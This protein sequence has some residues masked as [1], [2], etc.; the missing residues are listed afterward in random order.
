M[1]GMGPSFL[2]IL[3]QKTTL[4]CSLQRGKILEERI[5]VSMPVTVR[6]HFFFFNKLLLFNTF[7]ILMNSFMDRKSFK[8]YIYCLNITNAKILQSDASMTTI[9]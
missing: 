2:K 6:N 5:P 4:N 7:K 8:I 3:S 1:L 9:F